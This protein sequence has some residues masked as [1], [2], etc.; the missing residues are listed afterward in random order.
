[1]FCTSQSEKRKGGRGGKAGK[2]LFIM[3]CPGG[4]VVGATPGEKFLFRTLQRRLDGL[5]VHLIMYCPGRE[6]GGVVLG[7]RFLFRTVQ[8]RLGG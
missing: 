1:M 2:V 5:K 4:G 7:G 6:V 3:Y 8:R